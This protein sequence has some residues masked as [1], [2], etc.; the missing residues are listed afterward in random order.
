MRNK[1][2][3][4]GYLILFIIEDTINN[5]LKK[6]AIHPQLNPLEVLD[7]IPDNWKLADSGP[8]DGLVCFLNSVIS[9]TLH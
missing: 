6:Y 7:K 1:E 3:K 5:F 9:H 4:S 2:G 8:E